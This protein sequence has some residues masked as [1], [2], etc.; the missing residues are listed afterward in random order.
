MSTIRGRLAR[1]VCGLGLMAATTAAAQSMTTFTT[2]TFTPNPGGG[3]LV[4][5]PAV[6]KVKS[7][8]L[9]RVKEED[10]CCA[11]AIDLPATQLSFVDGLP[12]QGTYQ[13][14]LTGHFLRFGSASIQGTYYFGIL[15]PPPVTRGRVSVV[16]ACNPARQ[17]GAP[18]PNTVKQ[19][20]TNTATRAQVIW[21]PVAGAVAYKLERSADR[22]TWTELGC[23]PVSDRYWDYTRTDVPPTATIYPGGTYFYKVTAYQA[24]GAAGWNSGSARLLNMLQPGALSAQRVGNQVTLCWSYGQPGGYPAADRF[25]ITSSYGT[26]L[27]VPSTSKCYT[28]LGVPDGLHTFQ[29]GSA[30]RAIPT[31]LESPVATRRSISVQVSP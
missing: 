26:N 20:T 5:W 15:D 31:M 2:L 3:V 29:V 10:G 13:Y 9:S 22:V 14:T 4:S 25:V 7:Y 11:S 21:E 28:L 8:T 1:L 23:L 27:Q 16:T 24:D 30:Y 6:P 19:F 12:V 17:A 18:P